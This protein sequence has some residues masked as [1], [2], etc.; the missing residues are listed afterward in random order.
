MRSDQAAR[1]HQRLIQHLFNASAERHA[2]A[3]EPVLAP[4]YDDF[5]R[6]AAPH[7]ADR[8]L[9]AGTGTGSNARRIA[10]HV[11]SVTGVDVA[12]QPLIVACDQ[13]GFTRSR[14]LKLWRGGERTPSPDSA[15]PD[16]R[17][18]TDYV[19]ADLHQ[20]PFGAHHFT[21]IT[22]SFGLNATD[23]DRALVELRRVIAPGGRIV[24][25]EWGPVTELDQVVGEVLAAYTVD[26]PPPH[27]AALRAWIARDLANPGW[28]DHLQ[29][30][31]DYADWLRDLGFTV[32]DAREITPVVIPVSVDSFIACAVAGTDRAEELRAMDPSTRAACEAA[33]HVRLAAFADPAGWLR[34]EPVVIRAIGRA[35]TGA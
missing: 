11:R 4:L 6:Y 25:Q 21:L 9:D 5:V 33:L 16:T 31:D 35:V 28:A 12:V 17:E 29:D 10:P 34:W 24:I 13:R 26:D 2:C 19:C 3:V 30:A 14:D 23:P 1:D 32:A 18:G 15:S 22:A 7:P 20:L 27:L 8:V